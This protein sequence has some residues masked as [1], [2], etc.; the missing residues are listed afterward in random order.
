MID[1]VIEVGIDHTL[2]V[3]GKVKE[4]EPGFPVEECYRLFTFKMIHFE[5]SKGNP[6]YIDG[7]SRIEY[8][9]KRDHAQPS[10]LSVGG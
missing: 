8:Y 7:Y 3:F 4:K 9:F 5:K 6:L 2:Y 1:T 10:L